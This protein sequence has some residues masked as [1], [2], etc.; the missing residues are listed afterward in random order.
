M[1]R[2]DQQAVI[3]ESAYWSI[4]KLIDEAVAA[5]EPNPGKA[6]PTLEQGCRFENISFGY[7]RETVLEWAS[8]E[9]PARGLTV[10]TGASG[11][12][13]TTLTDLLLGFYQPQAGRILVDGV[14]LSEIDLQAWRGLH[15]YVPQELILFTDSVPATVA[16]V[17]P[18]LGQAGAG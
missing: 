10:I 5:R 12:G 2:Q 13:K 1:Q 17:A 4:R 11:S 16:L 6:V 7:G 3:F 14:P 9:I 15:C 18:P 8:L